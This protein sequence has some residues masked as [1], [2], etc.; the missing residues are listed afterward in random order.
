MELVK[1][2]HHAIKWCVG[3]FQGKMVLSSWRPYCWIGSFTSEW[4]AIT[5]LTRCC[6][7]HDGH[8][9]MQRHKRHCTSWESELLYWDA[10][11]AAQSRGLH[12]AD[13]FLLT[14]R[15]NSLAMCASHLHLVS[16]SSSYRPPAWFCLTSWCSLEKDHSAKLFP[17]YKR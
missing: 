4:D 15:V 12:D 16:K 2:E 5:Q 6:K 9:L 11:Q 17:M 13:V 3:S 8:L 7:I 14:A 10:A 1:F